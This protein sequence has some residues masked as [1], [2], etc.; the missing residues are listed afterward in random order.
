MDD[1]SVAQRNL[2]AELLCLPV[3][4]SYKRPIL[5]NLFLSCHLVSHWIP[6]WR[7]EEPEP[8][9]IQ[10]QGEWFYFKTVGLSP[11]L[12]L[13]WIWDLAHGF[14]SHSGFWLGLSPGTWVQVPICVL[15]RFRLLVLSVSVLL[16]CNTKEI[17]S[18]S[19]L[20][21]GSQNLHAEPLALKWYKFSKGRLQ[22]A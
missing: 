22:F 17:L 11:N 9:W 7:H 5:I 2:R 6:A 10:T 4:I 18:F 3:C 8:Q 1:K 16:F 15:A 13:G 20:F 21:T 12:A 14:K 19:S